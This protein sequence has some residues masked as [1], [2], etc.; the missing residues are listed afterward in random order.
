[1]AAIRRCFVAQIPLKL[2]VCVCVCMFM[3]LFI[4]VHF[5]WTHYKLSSVY[6]KFNEVNAD[7]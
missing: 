5:V 3:S 7:V 1:M 2:C 4:C 6:T